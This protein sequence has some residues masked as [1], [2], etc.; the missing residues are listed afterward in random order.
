[1]NTIRGENVYQSL[2]N[3]SSASYNVRIANGAAVPRMMLGG[4]PPTTGVATVIDPTNA[5]IASTS[6]DIYVPNPDPEMSGYINCG[7]QT[8]SSNYDAASRLVSKT[9]TMSNVSTDPS[10]SEAGGSTGD[11]PDYAYD[12]EN[13]Y[14]NSTASG[15]GQDVLWSPTGHAYRFGASFRNVHYDGA[16]ILFMTDQNGALMQTKIETMADI[17]ATGQMNV[18][19]RDFG[20]Q[21]VSRHS[22]VSYAGVWLGTTMYK[23]K[24]TPLDPIPAIFTKNDAKGYIDYDR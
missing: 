11:L 13:H 22:N 4:S 10:C 1:A 12:A 21:S 20:G 9:Q 18:L 14:I 8:T 24:D 5:V 3:S 15:I 16:G 6:K 19:D 23:N 17:D 2:G 7:N